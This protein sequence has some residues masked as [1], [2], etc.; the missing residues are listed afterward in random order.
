MSKT[1]NVTTTIS[2]D[3][4]KLTT[5]NIYLSQQ[6]QSLDTM[7][8]D[9]LSE[10]IDKTFAKAVPVAVQN[11]IALKNGAEFTKVDKTKLMPPRK[12][13]KGKSIGEQE[14][15]QSSQ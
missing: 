8:S 13:K 6:N 1:I 15:V 5:L 11:F 7:L 12:D 2:F 9:V 4:E 10:T 14:Q 3:E